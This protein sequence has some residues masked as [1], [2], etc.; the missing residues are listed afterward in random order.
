M[1]Y[2][3]GLIVLLVVAA[4]RRGLKVGLVRLVL[5]AFGL[6]VGLYLGSLAAGA[7][8]VYIDPPM[9]RFVTAIG[10]S[11]LV[12]A[13]ISSIGD[14]LGMLIDERAYRF[15]LE[16]IDTILG[17]FFEVGF[18]LFSVWLL[19]S[20]LASSSVGN[21]GQQIKDSLVIR[22]L[23]SV[24]PAPPD[25]LADLERVLSSNGFPTVFVGNE[26]SQPT[27]STNVTLNADIVATAE[28]SIVKIEGR[29]CGGKV[30]GTGFVV[31]PGIIATNAHV[32][33]GI[34]S[35]YAYVNTKGYPATTIYFDS[36]LDFALL[37]VKDF[38]LPALPL[39]TSLG[40]HGDE[41]AAIGYPGG[42][43]LTASGGTIIDTMT[44]LGR[45]I[46]GKGLVSREIYRV[47][48]A[49]QQGNSGSP[50]INS[51]GKAIGI[52]FAKS[53]SNDTVGYALLSK[54]ITEPVTKATINDAALSTG[55]CVA[56]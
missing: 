33:A 29:G 48:A 27:V 16:K 40:K 30:D 18:T 41:V 4:V 15:K 42:G 34:D 37:A 25:I 39:L 54:L 49:I 31:K 12:A 38:P 7:L 10:I 20:V 52:I 2:V 26:P 44:A 1:T 6:V 17:S 28:R 43:N 46:Y 53:V 22:G 50:L 55:Q 47:A 32:V 51:E 19:A 35:P 36:T 13:A 3:D 5:S 14:M 56:D 8:V 11:F 24:L 45:N 9:W 23:N 21:V